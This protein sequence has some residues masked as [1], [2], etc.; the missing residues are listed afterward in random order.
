MTANSTEAVNPP[1]PDPSIAED[2]A[3]G[4]M[5]SMSDFTLDLGFFEGPLDLL[6]YL[7][8]EHEVDIWEFRVAPITEQYLDYLKRLEEMDVYVASEF[9]VMAAYLLQLKSRM[10][11]PGARDDEEGEAPPEADPGYALKFQLHRLREFKRLAGWLSGKRERTE[12]EFWRTGN[13][14]EGME[15]E[16]LVDIGDFDLFNLI[17]LYRAVLVRT[18]PVKPVQVTRERKSVE[19]RVRELLESGLLNRGKRTRLSTLTGQAPS[20]P[21]VVVTFLALLEL[22]RLGRVRL[23]QAHPD[24][25]L[26]VTFR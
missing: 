14:R 11:L 24:E 16:G 21:E 18:A 23:H 5:N 26:K 4:R 1:V 10:M 22:A 13:L 8:R 2:T 19:E 17:T 9:I 7:I 3:G 20:I 12:G 15:L 25:E 6:L